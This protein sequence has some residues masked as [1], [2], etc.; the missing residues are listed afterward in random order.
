MAQFTALAANVPS[1]NALRDMFNDRLNE[2]ICDKLAR[3]ELPGTL[4][5][6]IA[7][8]N[9]IDQFQEIHRW[10]KLE[11]ACLLGLTP[12]NYQTAGQQGPYT[13]CTSALAPMAQ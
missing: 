11:W 12:S 5:E 6:L 13:A 8:A 2:N 10:S 7:K 9:H 4:T 3:D 1:N